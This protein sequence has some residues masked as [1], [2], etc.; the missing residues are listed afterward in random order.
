MGIYYGLRKPAGCMGFLSQFTEEII[1]LIKIGLTIVWKNIPVRLKGVCC[2]A[3]AKGFILG[4][5]HHNGY[6]SCTLYKQEGSFFNNRMTFP[7][8][9][10]VPQTHAGSDW[11]TGP[12][13]GIYI[14]ALD[15][16][17]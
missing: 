3:P 9:N 8:F 17:M 10:C 1:L 15:Q 5:K 4:I 12:W 2:D 6:F 16:M 11:P 14:C 13:A 7:L